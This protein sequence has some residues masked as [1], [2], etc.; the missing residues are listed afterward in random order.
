MEIATY[1]TSLISILFI[2]VLIFWFYRGYR[3]DSFRQKMFLLRDNLFDEA[4]NGNIPFESDAYGMLRSTING[5][6]R[7]AHKLSLWQIITFLILVKSDKKCMGKSFSERL[8]S[9]LKGMKAEEIKVIHEQHMYLNFLIVEHILLSSPL[10]L[11]TVLIPIT[12][13]LTAKKH[14]TRVIAPF[15][16]PLDKLDSA[17]FAIGRI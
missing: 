8:E 4:M 17:A 12:F 5:A 6:I 11:L 1:F 15:K 10:I 3:V 2:F 14:I 13:F 9:K 16:F 7:F